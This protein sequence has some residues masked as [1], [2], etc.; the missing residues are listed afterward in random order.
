M[1]RSYPIRPH[2]A[3]GYTLVEL[4]VTLVLTL[5]LLSAGLSFYMLSRNSYATIDDSANLQERGN[6]A[7]SVVTRQ[8]RQTAF[9]PTADGMGLMTV[10]DPML[11]GV[12]SCSN[13]LVKTVAG[14]EQLTCAGGTSVNNSDAVMVRFFGISDSTTK[15][16]DGSMVD[17]AGM[18]VGT[19]TDPALA[20]QQRGLSVL[21]VATGSNGK[22]SLMCQYPL[23]KDGAVVAGSYV[24]Q[25]LVPGVEA[26]QVLY[27][28]GLNEDEVPDKYVPASQV[29]AAEWKQ[30][31]TAKVSMVIR[32]DNASAD[33]TGPGTFSLFGALGA[34]TAD[35]SFQPTQDLNSA[36]KLFSA[37][38]QMH[39]Y[40]SCFQGDN[41][42]L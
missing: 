11:G 2:R 20:G 7:M 41:S 6:F 5:L 34:K 40:L 42:C 1:R 3:A 27:G 12:D 23:R 32:T 26:F 37:T 24:T 18:G 13:P 39:N 14:V 17:C 4:M 9:T 28:I 19:F 22:P 33:S 38:V 8:L 10:D 30:V 15:L 16:P 36:R 25:E 29:A 35:S 31:L 21:Y